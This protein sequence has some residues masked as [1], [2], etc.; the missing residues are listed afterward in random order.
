MAT[1]VCFH[2]HPDDESIS[3]G[4]LMAKAAAAGHRVV[5]VI[6]TRG[7]RGEVPDGFLEPG[8]QLGIRR[9]AETMRSAEVLGVARTEFLGYVDSGM[10]GT[11]ENEGPYAFWQ[12]EVE[13]AAGRLAQLL[14]D[15]HADVLTIYDEN[16]G[17]GH[18][19]HIQVHRVG[20]RAAEIAGVTRVFEATMNRDSMRRG[21]VESI[22]RGDIGSD[23]FPDLDAEPEFGMPEARITHAVD[24][25]AFVGAKRDS[26]RCHASQISDE[27]FFL[28][29]PE[30][31]FAS[32][33]GTEWF[34]E[35]GHTRAEGAPMGDDLFA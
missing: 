14:T 32:A 34:I 16:G 12:A 10:I 17:Y 18:P 6:A 29:M 31:S 19:D 7:E 4:G 9:I 2:A 26:M 27:A 22:E 28:Q 20:A 23:Q 1:I 8:E 24:V 13:Q 3:T 11:P 35:H 33:F 5:L 25:T 30:E 15:E 21:I